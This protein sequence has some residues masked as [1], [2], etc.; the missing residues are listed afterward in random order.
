MYTLITNQ[1]LFQLFSS[2][3]TPTTLYFRIS[4][5]F[6]NLNLKWKFEFQME[7]FEVIDY[8]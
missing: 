7:L 5:K 4:N 3:P 1:R 2:A 8:T 6:E